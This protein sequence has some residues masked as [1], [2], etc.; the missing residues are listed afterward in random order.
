MAIPPAWPLVVGRPHACPA[1]AGEYTA[2]WVGSRVD[3][4]LPAYSTR[5]FHQP[6]RG[7]SGGAAG[8]A[9][10]VRSTGAGGGS[11]VAAPLIS[12]CSLGEAAAEAAGSSSGWRIVSG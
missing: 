7:G 10:A 2:A 5:R 4:R 6:R 3:R 12:R 11:A 9:G 1:H 8:S